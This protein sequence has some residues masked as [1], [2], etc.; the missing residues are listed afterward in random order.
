MPNGMDTLTLAVSMADIL[1]FRHRQSAEW[2]IEEGVSFEWEAF[3]TGRWFITSVSMPM[4]RQVNDWAY[5]QF[6]RPSDEL[7]VVE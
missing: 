5:N 2:L 7:Q 3:G 4:V 6:R 1:A